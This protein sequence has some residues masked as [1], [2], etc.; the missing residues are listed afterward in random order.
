LTSPI[1]RGFFASIVFVLSER[2]MERLW[3]FV[4]VEEIDLSNGF[5]VG[6]TT[7]SVSSSRPKIIL[8]YLAK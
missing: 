5:A 3:R 8:I 2:L 4:G 1:P 6:T 7:S